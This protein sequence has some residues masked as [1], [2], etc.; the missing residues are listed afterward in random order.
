MSDEADFKFAQEIYLLVSRHPIRRI[1]FDMTEE[2]FAAIIA[3][4]FGHGDARRNRG[5]EAGL[6]CARQ[7][8]DPGVGR[9][10]AA[11]APATHAALYRA[12]RQRR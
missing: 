5:V 3:R 11:A 12:I 1:V 2:E 10:G 9:A 8:I 6:A 7:G 4:A